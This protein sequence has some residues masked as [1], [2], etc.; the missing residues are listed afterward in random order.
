MASSWTAPKTWTVGE[1]FTAADTNLY[2][3]DNTTWLGTDAPKVRVYATMSQSIAT[4]GSPTPITFGAER[5]DN[6]N[7]HSSTSSTSKLIIPTGKGGTYMIGGCIAFPLA[8]AV[9]ERVVRVMLNGTTELVSQGVPGSTIN[10]PNL[11]VATLYALAAGDYVELTA[12][13]SN[14]TALSS[15]PVS[16]YAPEFW[17]YWVST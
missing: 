3:R 6:Q 1:L 5:F 8:S 17:A 4:G 10:T 15:Q 16:N 11:A 14:G 9:G 7:L 2:I 13:Q 12:F